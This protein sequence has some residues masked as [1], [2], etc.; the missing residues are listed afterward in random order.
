M[1]TTPRTPPGYFGAAAGDPEEGYYA[2]DRGNWHVVVL[3]S[4]CEATSPI[5]TWLERDLDAN[6]QACAL[7]YFH[8]PLFSSGMHGNEPERATWDVLYTA[9]ANLVVNDHECFAS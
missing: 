5:L 8:H 3:N 4:M 2:Y 7:A 6:S 1:I 9:N